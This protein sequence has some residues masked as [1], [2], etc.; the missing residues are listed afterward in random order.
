MYVVLVFYKIIV[1]V[2]DTKI[3][4]LVKQKLYHRITYTKDIN[5]ALISTSEV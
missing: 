4:Y 3:I 5:I 2:S 1:V